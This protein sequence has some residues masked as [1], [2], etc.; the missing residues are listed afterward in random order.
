MYLFVLL[1]AENGESRFDTLVQKEFQSWF[2]KLI[3]P[4][5]V[6][7]GVDAENQVRGLHFLC[8]YVP[9]MLDKNK[10]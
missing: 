2:P 7:A 3:H 4:L 8:R 5:C 1:F 10:N 9:A 6:Q